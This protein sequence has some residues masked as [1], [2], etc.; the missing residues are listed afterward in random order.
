[1]DCFFALPPRV[2]RFSSFFLSLSPGLPPYF[3]PYLLESLVGLSTAGVALCSTSPDQAAFDVRYGGLVTRNAYTLVAA[4]P[5][6]DN[7]RGV[8]NLNSA[9]GG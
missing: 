9:Q 7:L 4:L 5:P 3:T 6:L 2:S 8:D 1:M